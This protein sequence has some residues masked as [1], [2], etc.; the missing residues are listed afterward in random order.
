[1]PF[2]FKQWG[3]WVPFA[4]WATHGDGTVLGG[5][6]GGPCGMRPLPNGRWS[7]H[8]RTGQIKTAVVA[9]PEDHRWGR[10]NALH[11][12]Y[13][14]VGKKLAGRLLDGREWNEIPGTED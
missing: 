3:E 7:V 5:D 8:F 2:V 14:R 1:V 9:E 10:D 6:C 13:C 12:T 4:T 11:C